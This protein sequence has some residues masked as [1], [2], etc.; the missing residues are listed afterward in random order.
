[1]LKNQRNE[2]I[3]SSPIFVGDAVDTEMIRYDDERGLY[4]HTQGGD[5]DNKLE[6]ET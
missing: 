5:I 4:Y 1:M 2:Y 3:P 6:F